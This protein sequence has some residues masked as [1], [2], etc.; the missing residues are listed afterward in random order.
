VPL[1]VKGD[2]LLNH[3]LYCGSCGG[4][5]MSSTN[6]KRCYRRQDGTIRK[7]RYR[8]YVCYTRKRYRDDCHGRYSIR[9]HVIEDVVVNAIKNYLDKLGAVEV[10]K[11]TENK[12]EAEITVTRSQLSQKQKELAK[13]KHEYESLQMEIIKVINGESGF[14]QEVLMEL[15][16]IVKA[17][18]ENIEEQIAKLEEELR[19]SSELAISL[20]AEGMRLL[21]YAEIFEDTDSERK[22]MI[23]RDLIDRVTLYGD[24]IDIEWKISASDYFGSM[25]TSVDGL[26]EKGR[27]R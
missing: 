12:Y 11:I 21:S 25:K 13:K 17:E 27:E 1:N 2:N 10:S 23:V 19:T 8:Q 4:K 18:K 9:A 26:I 15:I 20:K 6:G 5:F 3:I 7:D 16:G 22:K 14:T 24:K